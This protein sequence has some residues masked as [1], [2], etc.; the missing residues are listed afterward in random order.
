MNKKN[1]RKIRLTESQLQK[2]ILKEFRPKKTMPGGDVIT[3]SGKKYRVPGSPKKTRNR[4]AVEDIGDGAGD[5]EIAFFDSTQ[6]LILNFESTPSLLEATYASVQSFVSNNWDDLTNGLIEGLYFGDPNNPGNIVSDPIDTIWN[7]TASFLI[8]RGQ[9]ISDVASNFELAQVSERLSKLRAFEGV[10]VVG[11]FAGQL[12]IS[13]ESLEQLCDFGITLLSEPISTENI[14]DLFQIVSLL[15]GNKRSIKDALGRSGE[16]NSVWSDFKQKYMKG[17]I[18]IFNATTNAKIQTGEADFANPGP[19]MATDKQ[20]VVNA[21]E[22]FKH[23]LWEQGG[24]NQWVMFEGDVQIATKTVSR[25]EAGPLDKLLTFIGYGDA[26]QEIE[27]PDPENSTFNFTRTSP[28]NQ[29]IIE[30]LD[31][32]DDYYGRQRQEAQNTLNSLG[33]TIQ[34]SLGDQAKQQLE[35]F[36]SLQAIM[37]STMKISRAIRRNLQVAQALRLPGQ[38]SDTS[39]QLALQFDESI[40]D[41][42][43]NKKLLLEQASAV[44]YA[45]NFGD[46]VD[47]LANSQGGPFTGSELQN[48][49]L[50]DEDEA[51]LW[52]GPDQNADPFKMDN[53]MGNDTWPGPD[54]AGLASAVVAFMFTEEGMARTGAYINDDESEVGL[55]NEDTVAFY[56]L[57]M[58][59][60]DEDNPKWINIL[61]QPDF[62]VAFEEALERQFGQYQRVIKLPPNPEEDPEK[63]EEEDKKGKNCP[64]DKLSVEIEALPDNKARTLKF[65]KII[66]KYIT[67]HD[68][69]GG[70]IGEDGK[71]GPRTDE[72]FERVLIH[73]LSDTL[74]H[75]V[76][77]DLNLN[78]NAISSMASKW[79]Q[80]ARRLNRTGYINS[81]DNGD[82]TGALAL[83]YDLYNCND[84]YGKKT[85]K[86]SGVP[87]KSTP[88]KSGKPRK[89]GA[90]NDDDGVES[91]GKCADGSAMKKATWRDIQIQFNQKSKKFALDPKSVDQ[92]KV[93]LA[94]QTA[95][96]IVNPPHNM[97][98]VDR[99]HVGTF[100]V[101]MGGRIKNRKSH[102]WN[103]PDAY[104]K[105]IDKA[106]KNLIQKAKKDSKGLDVVRNSNIIITI[107]CGNYTTLAESIRQKR[108]KDFENL[109]RELIKKV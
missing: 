87:K 84:E 41:R 90:K 37:A 9:S 20:I 78:N 105:I 103:V 23:A 107:P 15:A 82:I 66:N 72:G 92:L 33:N 80:N 95:A 19:V 61:Y 97:N 10:D 4:Q 25:N 77:G 83:V 18:E 69:M 13:I 56:I 45:G 104:E 17:A 81:N 93:D 50:T 57:D 30:R 70:S 1:K 53:L 36:K 14:D 86:R 63:P 94:K 8:Q 85:I 67:H 79:K 55:P 96:F 58:K 91:K 5:R 44:N 73:G 32:L 16:L 74:N 54:Y 46:Y 52:L 75:P 12:L 109:L 68:L 28:G 43:K 34:N 65:Q 60:E 38:G 62:A 48:Y 76:Y 88:E 71:W 89:V 11:S 3:S 108:E 47:Q 24:L 59:S 49:T 27:V 98:P 100:T 22:Y 26:N 35:A 31:F 7:W 40:R 29:T 99:E 39:V 102:D 101:G 51:A 2:L 64:K 21:L 106:M 42:R 6:K